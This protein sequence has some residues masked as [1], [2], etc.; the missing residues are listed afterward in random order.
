MKLKTILVLLVAVVFVSS[1]TF[2]AEVKEPTGKISISYTAVAAGIGFSWGDGKLM[3]DGKTYRFSVKGIKALD[4]AIAGV[5]AVGEVYN[6][7]NVSDFSGTFTEGE[8]G[9]AL[10]GG[11]GA[12]TLKNQNGVVMSLRSTQRGAR[13]TL[14]VGGLKVKLK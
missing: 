6:L 7:N 13:L 14:G 1:M 11:Y 12:L 4:V 8:I 3:I 2:A 9:F 5:S 10:A